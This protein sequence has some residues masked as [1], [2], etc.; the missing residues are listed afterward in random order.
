MDFRCI[1]SL[2]VYL[3]LGT[4]LFINVPINLKLFDKNK[5]YVVAYGGLVCIVVAIVLAYF[6]P[7]PYRWSL[8]L[9]IVYVLFLYYYLPKE[10]WS[11]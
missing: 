1:I 6:Y 3:F 9:I 7:L 2:F 10:A 5:D 8:G 11:T 4:E